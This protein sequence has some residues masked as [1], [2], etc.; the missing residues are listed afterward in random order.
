M[1]TLKKILESN[2]PKQ[3]VVEHILHIIC[4]SSKSLF[5]FCCIQCSV[6]SVRLHCIGNK[7]APHK[8][9]YHIGFGSVVARL[10]LLRLLNL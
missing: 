1:N 7:I 5:I 6:K 9:W 8:I 10:I 2:M 4:V 3:I